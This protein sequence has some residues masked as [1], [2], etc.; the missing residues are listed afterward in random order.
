MEWWWDQP[1][2]PHVKAFVAR[3]EE[4]HGQEPDRAA[5][6]RLCFGADI[7]AAG[8]SGKDRRRALSSPT[9]CKA[10]K[11]PPEIAM[12]PG[13]PPNIAPATTSS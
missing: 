5:L 10:F 9:R 3:H 11:L 13:A 1:D 6:V 4:S 7:R 8:Q 2:N 12:Q